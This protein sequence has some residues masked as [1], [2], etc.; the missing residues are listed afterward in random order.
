MFAAPHKAL[1]KSMSDFIIRVGQT[2][3][4]NAESISMLKVFGAELFQLLSSHAH[5]EDEII[6]G[7]LDEKI[8]GS[9][10]HDKL[11]HA[12]IEHLQ[13]R[14]E[15]E[16]YQLQA[17]QDDRRLYCFYQNFS[18]FQ[19]VY[20][21]HMHEEETTTQQLIWVNLSIEEQLAIRGKI[22]AH[23]EPATYILWLKH[24]IP[25]QNEHENRLL[26]DT[27]RSNMPVERFAFIY[28]H[29]SSHLGAKLDE[30]L[31]AKFNNLSIS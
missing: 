21:E 5:T 28:Q 19:S 31:Q 27:I 29:L 16:L 20:L 14:L 13:E 18:A 22:V 25:A 23:M 24:M 26:L 9:S 2:D 4:R 6:L 30:L 1:R 8:P 7:A 3:Y 17:E 10:A 12:K 15:T 11:D